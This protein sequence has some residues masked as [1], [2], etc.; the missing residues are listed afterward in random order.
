MRTALHKPKSYKAIMVSSTF[1]DLKEHRQK[2]IEAIEKFK[3]KAN[4]MEFDAGRADA[5]VIESSLEMVRH[6]AVYIGLIS[7][8]YGQ[9]P[10]CHQQ[11]PNRL[12]LTE[13]EFNEAMRLDRPILL[14]IMSENHLLREADI[15]LEPDKREK[16]DAFRSRAKRMDENSE[17]ERVYISFDSCES[18]GFSAACAIGNLKRSQRRRLRRAIEPEPQRASPP[19]S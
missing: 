18:F 10:F 9:T 16:L 3:Y 5:D 13:L 6:S 7:R 2:V 1:T 19:P 8:K 14:F 4:A 12:S 17:V 11:N 15:E